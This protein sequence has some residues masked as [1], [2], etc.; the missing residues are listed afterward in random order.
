MD[1]L[2][3][4]L[5]SFFVELVRVSFY[6]LVFPFFCAQF[7]AE[8]K[9]NQRSAFL[10]IYLL[11]IWFGVAIS[12][13]LFFLELEGPATYLFAA[14]CVGGL[15]GFIAMV[16]YYIATLS[17]GDT[18]RLESEEAGGTKSRYAQFLTIVYS[19]L[20]LLCGGGV[21]YSSQ[22]YTFTFQGRLH[23]VFKEQSSVTP[24]YFDLDAKPIYWRIVDA[25]KPLRG[26]IEKH[27]PKQWQAHLKERKTLI[28]RFGRTAKRLFR[29]WLRKKREQKSD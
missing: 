15:I 19:V 12:I 23:V 11:V 17:R 4:G 8:Q 6:F 28:R 24:M 9:E 26:Y 2:I 25:S 20:L 18:P 7:Y 27:Y 16:P 10:P 5:V 21:L 13:G 14:S 3:E 29:R 22:C 1:D